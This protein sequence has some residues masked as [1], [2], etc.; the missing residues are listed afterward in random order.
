[1]VN[2]IDDLPV[3]G[4]RRGG[5]AAA[6]AQHLAGRPRPPGAAPALAPH[7]VGYESDEDVDNGFRPRRPD[8]PV[9]HD[10]QHPEYLQDF[11]NT[12]AA[13]HHHAPPDAVPGGE[14]RAGLLAPAPSSGP[15]ASTTVTTATGAAADARMQ[16]ATVNLFA[17]MGVQP[18][19]LMSGLVAATK[20]TDTAGPTADHR[21]RRPPARH[22]PTAARSPS[23]APPPTPAGMVA[24]VEV[25]TDGGATWHPAT[26]TDGLDLQRRRTGSGTGAIQVRAV[27]DSA[28]IGAVASRTVTVTG[29]LPVFGDSGAGRR[30]RSATPIAVELGVKFTPNADGFITGRPLLQGRRRT[31]ARTPAPLWSATGTRLATG[32]FTDETATGWQTLD[33][34]RPGRRH[35]RHHLRRLVHAPTGHYAA[36][37]GLLLPRHRASR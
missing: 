36:D 25:S 24:G 28:N 14:R 17:D 21:P 23:R 26:G 11:G 37:R 8:P 33:L 32:T 16:Q 19:T 15:G 7:T 9:D 29:P 22:V 12:V 4:P 27:D 6:L 31:P 1:M 18:A 5:Q 13:G 34:R 3:D 20:T 30:R 35:R 2:D 10:R